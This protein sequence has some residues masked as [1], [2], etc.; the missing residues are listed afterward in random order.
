MPIQ[1]LDPAIANEGFHA[2]RDVVV[3]LNDGSGNYQ[4]AIPRPRIP[5]LTEDSIPKS[6]KKY[7]PQFSNQP[8]TERAFPA[9][10]YH[11][12]KAPIL[13][14]DEYYTNGEGEKVLKEKAAEKASRLGIRY[15]GPG[16]GWECTGEWHPKPIQPHG[17]NVKDTGK[18]VAPVD[19]RNDQLAA[20][21]TKAMAG[22]NSSADQATVVA[23]AVAAALK[24]V[25]IGTH[26]VEAPPPAPQV[27]ALA[28]T[29]PA[30]EEKDILIGLAKEKGIKIDGRWSVDR[31]KE[32]LDQAA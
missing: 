26:P 32:A 22:A 20:A 17:P 13:I 11:A 8:Y 27:N 15:R 18:S 9:W 5:F 14:A 2:E 16:Q 6:I 12:T 1:Y 3:D 24:A 21:I 29:L 7:F 4:P 30:D 25:G 10:F 28:P 31:I 23:A 19:N